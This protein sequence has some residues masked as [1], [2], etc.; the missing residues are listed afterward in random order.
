MAELL[1]A[2]KASALS[3]CNGLGSGSRQQGSAQTEKARSSQTGCRETFHKRIGS[4]FRTE[5]IVKWAQRTACIGG[6]DASGVRSKTG[7][8]LLLTQS[9][10]ARPQVSFTRVLAEKRFVK[11][12]GKSSTVKGTLTVVR[13]SLFASK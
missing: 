9:R 12:I 2:D 5:A 10:P 3:A 7:F 13:S 8:W 6:F 1:V 4:I 11:G